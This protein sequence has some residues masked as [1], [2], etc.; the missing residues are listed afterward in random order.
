[1]GYTTQQRSGYFDRWPKQAQAHTRFCPGPTHSYTADGLRGLRE[2]LDAPSEMHFVPALSGG[3][4]GEQMV[5]GQ[6]VT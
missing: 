2:K 3:S 4:A 1:M 5:E 6:R